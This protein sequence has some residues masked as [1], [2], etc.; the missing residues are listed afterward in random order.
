MTWVRFPPATGISL[1]QNFS[2]PCTDS[3]TLNTRVFSPTV[4]ISPIAYLPSPSLLLMS[5]MSGTVP[6]C[7]LH[8]ILAWHLG[9]A[10]AYLET[11]INLVRLL[12][13]YFKRPSLLKAVI[14]VAISAGWA[15]TVH[16][17]AGRVIS[18]LRHVS[19]WQ[20]PS[21]CTAYLV[22]ELIAK[23][24]RWH[25]SFVHISL[26]YILLTWPSRP[27]IWHS[28]FVFGRFLVQI[29]ARSPATSV[30]VFGVFLQ[31]RKANAGVVH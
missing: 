25:S 27:S 7:F 5:E 29:S 1:P 26:L 21:W 14:L 8:A 9:T 12:K 10:L 20:L 28:C 15:C 23:H 16:S 18:V 22:W 17:G 13:I 4:K 6:P 19:S 31:S 24:Y 11:T 30:E 3:C 2:R